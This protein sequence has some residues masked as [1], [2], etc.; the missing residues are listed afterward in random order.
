MR[1]RVAAV[2]A[3]AAMVSALVVPGSVASATPDR[4]TKRAA[5]TAAPVLTVTPNT[6]L[7]DTENIEVVGSGFP[8]STVVIAQC[9][10]NASCD[11]GFPQSLVGSDGSFDL[12]MSVHVR[13]DSSGVP[14]GN[15]VATPCEMRISLVDGTVLARA[16]LT[17]RAS[18]TLPPLV[19]VTPNTGLLHDQTVLVTGEAFPAGAKV[20]LIECISQALFC[21]ETLQSTSVDAGDDG[22][23]AA[24]VKVSRLLPDPPPGQRAF[25]DCA[26]DLSPCTI[27][28]VYAGVGGP[29][30]YGSTPIRFDA[31]VAA[32]ALPTVTFTPPRLFPANDTAVFDLAHFTP[33]HPLRVRFC[34][35]GRFTQK[36]CDAWVTATPDTSGVAHVPIAVHR[37]TTTSNGTVIDCAG[38]G[39]C[40]VEAEGTFAYERAN[41]NV[42]FDPTATIPGRPSIALHDLTVTEGSDG[43]QTPAR[44]R[45]TLSGPADRPIAVQWASDFVNQA[46]FNP[47]GGVVTIPAGA[48]EAR[49]PLRVVADRTDEPDVALT[50]GIG[51]DGYTITRPRATLHI[52][53]DDLPSADPPAVAWLDVGTGEER[54]GTSRAVINLVGPA[55][56]TVIVHYRTTDATAVAGSDYVAK[57]S[58][59]VFLPGETRHVLRFQ[60]LN[61][62]VR[63][64]R[65]HFH[66]LLTKVD[67]GIAA[68]GNNVD[69][70]DDD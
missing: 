26:T 48:V 14:G 68:R 10:V 55:R 54:T 49:I 67:G 31:S 42:G 63:E 37:L 43:G 23:F 8:Q 65:E 27:Q 18:Q 28:G 58:S 24:F 57:R 44:M 39:G 66:V 5:A 62:G 4:V 7:V 11:L 60:I 17:F 46:D 56:H 36:V 29:T 25:R 33:G 19:T 12:L 3:A 52:I 59:I 6:D 21:A 30:S 20:F 32:P 45:I 51:A 61:D 70:F 1:R 13:T 69:I 34:A 9:V 47:P 41:T 2:V 35:Q 16:P 64:G 22:R 50:V 15:C 53:D 40:N 38:D